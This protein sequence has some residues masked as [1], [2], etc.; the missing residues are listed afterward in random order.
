MVTTGDYEGSVMASRNI[1]KQF[2]AL[3][4]A[5]FIHTFTFHIHV[6]PLQSCACEYSDMSTQYLYSCAVPDDGCPVLS[7]H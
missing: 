6:L 5:I 3:P 4:V 1:N 7:C 2:L